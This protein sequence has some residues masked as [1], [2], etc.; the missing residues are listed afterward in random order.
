[1]AAN[2]EDFVKRMTRM[3]RRF[4]FIFTD[5]FFNVEGKTGILT[6]RFRDIRATI[7]NIGH[8]RGTRVEEHHNDNVLLFDVEVAVVKGFSCFITSFEELASGP[9]SG[10]SEI[11]GLGVEAVDAQK[12]KYAVGMF[13]SEKLG[14]TIPTTKMIADRRNRQLVLVAE[15]PADLKRPSLEPI[16]KLRSKLTTILINPNKGPIVDCQVSKIYQEGNSSSL[17]CM[18]NMFCVHYK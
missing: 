16:L 17:S 4:T 10:S 12:V 6:D 14:Q 11:H 9:F 8:R 2:V 13:M 18:L 7:K 5:D 15:S 1:M 3:S